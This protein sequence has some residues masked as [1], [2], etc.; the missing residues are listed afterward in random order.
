M[1]PPIAPPGGGLSSKVNVVPGM[2]GSI[3]QMADAATCSLFRSHSDAHMPILLHVCTPLVR[4]H[5]PSGLLDACVLHLYLTLAL[6]SGR[7][8]ESSQGWHPWPKGI[9]TPVW[10]RDGH[11][12][13]CAPCD[14]GRGRRWW[15]RERCNPA[16]HCL[17]AMTR[18]CGIE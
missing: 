1:G 4:G 14:W 7:G 15:G 10:I 6:K 2:S 18:H 16:A 11:P 17:H 13:C 9:L 3:R 8:K 12:S 5:P